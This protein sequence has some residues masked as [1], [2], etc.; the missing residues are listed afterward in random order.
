MQRS[1]SSPTST[2]SPSDPCTGARACSTSVRAY[3]GAGLITD[4]RAGHN[5]LGHQ[6]AADALDVCRRRHRRPARLPDLRARQQSVDDR[7]GLRAREPVLEPGRAPH[8]GRLGASRTPSD[9]L[10]QR[11]GR[12]ATRR[13]RACWSSPST[14]SRPT[15][16]RSWPSARCTGASG[17][18]VATP[19]WAASRA[20]VWYF[21]EGAQGGPVELRHVRAPLQPERDRC[22]RR[23]CRVLRRGRRRQGRH[24]AASRRSRAATSTRDSIPTSWPAWTR[25]SRFV[26]A[27]R[28]VS[29]SSP[30]APSTGAACAKAAP[31]PGSPPPRASGGSPTGRK[32]GS[33]SSRIRAD[34]N[35]RP[36]STFYLVLN[37]TA[38]A[39]LGAGRVL[40]RTGAW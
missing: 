34:P 6:C 24:R 30:S 32:A 9:V 3:S 26:P 2:S 19:R 20:P 14:S 35:W 4:L 31:R 7:R 1:R 15:A 18:T 29:H 16:C 38:A 21:A 40:C 12:Q 5:V 17:S 11:R 13:A 28:R 36:F 39:D 22:H 8:R 37:P 23:H 33:R 25:R 10:G 27:A